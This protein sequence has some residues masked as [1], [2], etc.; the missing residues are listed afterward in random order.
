MV[1]GCLR[2]PAPFVFNTS[3]ASH[4]AG[5]RAIEATLAP[6]V[7]VDDGSGYQAQRVTFALER[8]WSR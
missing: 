3:P 6:R 1:S 7:D 5:R 8:E 4:A 2:R